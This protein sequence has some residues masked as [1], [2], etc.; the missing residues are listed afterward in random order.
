MFEI[1]LSKILPPEAIEVRLELELEVRLKGKARPRFNKDTGIV[2]MPGDYTR[3][4]ADLQWGLRAAMLKQPR[5]FSATAKYAMEVKLLRKRRK[6][7]NKKEALTIDTDLP[8]GSMIGGKPDWDN[9]A[10]T[11]ADAGNKIIYDDD[12]Q[13]VMALVYRVLSDHDGAEITIIKLAEGS[14]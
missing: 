12:T 3:H 13:V 5:I 9:A 10:G 4:V 8:M 1:L 7:K 2:Y 6:P 11:I 14:K